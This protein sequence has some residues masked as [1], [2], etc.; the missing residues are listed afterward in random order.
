MAPKEIRRTS[1]ILRQRG[2]LDLIDG[3]LL[4]RVH[5]NLHTGGFSVESARGEYR[6]VVVCHS[7]EV[8]IRAV[9]PIVSEV[10]RQRMLAEGIRNVH[11]HLAGRLVSV[12]PNPTW[13][14]PA[15]DGITRR[16][17]GPVDGGTRGVPFHGGGLPWMECRYRTFEDARFLFRALPDEAW[18]PLAR[19]AEAIFHGGRCWVLDPEPV[20]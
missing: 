20:G 13:R 1:R 14:Y 17:V 19:A 4:V 11:A 15:E 3:E 10:Q 2:P 6:G 12:G 18:R 7:Q 16:F 5:R 9:V 8:R